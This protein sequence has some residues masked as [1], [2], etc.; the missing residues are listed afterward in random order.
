MFIT[1]RYR[2]KSNTKAL[3]RQA[4]AINC[5]WNYCNET[6]RKAVKDGRKWISAFEL[7]RLTSGTSKD[8][9]L[10]ATSINQVCKV[11]HL[12]RKTNKKAWLKFRGNN[13][14]GW[15][16]F[17]KG[18]IKLVDRAFA[19]NGVNYSVFGSRK[20]PIEAEIKDGS[21]FSQ[22][23]KGR[24]YLNLVLEI[25]IREAQNPPK[26]VGIDLG[27]KDTATLSNG[28]K[29]EAK[30]F[31]RKQETRLAQAQRGN[32]KKIVRSIHAK[33]ANKRKDFLH[34]VSYRITS[35][36]NQVYIGDVSSSALAKTNLAKSVNDSGWY[37]F[38]K[39]LAY[40]SIRN[41]GTFKKV[42]ERFT[43]Q[44]CSRCGSIGGPKGYAGL[45]ERVWSC[46]HCGCTHDR[47]VNSAINILR[48]ATQP[49]VQGAAVLQNV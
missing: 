27:F 18:S 48:L 30:H 6:Q 37:T 20:I 41:G 43:T 3:D 42:S 38:K 10:P 11:H 26:P 9:G 22:D 36:F 29:I 33:I 12:S 7:M 5:V 25:P 40:K 45:N 14:L 46:K 15:V 34:K 24:W 8:L 47:D 49:P 23:A 1:Y 17:R 31:Y 32:K 19:F 13:S 4:E 28:E 35:K 2:I 21:S 39:M 44:T 16:P